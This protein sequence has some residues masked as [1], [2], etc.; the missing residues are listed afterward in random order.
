MIEKRTMWYVD[1]EYPNY[2]EQS[3][4]VFMNTETN[5][6][7]VYDLGDQECYIPDDQD[8]FY[9]TQDEA[10]QALSR[11]RDEIREMM[12]KVKEFVEMMDNM[13]STD[14][15]NFKAEEYLGSYRAK[16]K[17]WSYEDDYNN[18]TAKYSRLLLVARNGVMNVNADTF[19]VSD[20]QRIEWNNVKTIKDG[21]EKVREAATVVLKDGRKI[22]TRHKAEYALIE[23]L[24]GDN[25]S[26]RIYT[27]KENEDD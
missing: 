21:E 1:M 23:D 6:V 11:R 26:N 19:K 7:E 4:T 17:R 10:V 27:V 8:R 18:M 2:K 22:R 12:P 16:F 20:I 24:F 13:S 15:F 25:M 9:N 14:D 5:E 3:V